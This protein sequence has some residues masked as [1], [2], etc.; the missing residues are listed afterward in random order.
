MGEVAE[1]ERSTKMDGDRRSLGT[2]EVVALG[3]VVAATALLFAQTRD[4]A[5]VGWDTYP[6]I[7]ASRIQSTEDFLRSFGGRLMG[8]DLESAYYRPLLNATLAIDYAINGLSPFGYQATNALLFAGCGLA[9]FAAYRQLS[10]SRVGALSALVVFLLHPVHFE[11]VPVVSRRPELLCLLFTLLAVAG[12]ARATRR[13]PGR[14]AWLPA[15][16]GLLA[17]SSKETG[18]VSLPLVWLISLTGEPGEPG[19]ERVRRSAREMWPW[20]P[21]TLTLI[22]IRYGVLG[23]FVG[24]T[25]D[26]TVALGLLYPAGLRV[27]R[28]LILAR[29]DLLSLA[30]AAL[31]LAGTVSCAAACFVTRARMDA[32]R[33]AL[34]GA[35]LLVLATSLY[36]AAGLVQPWYLEIPLAGFALMWGAAIETLLA[37]WRS[38]TAFARCVVA[39]GLLCGVAL[40]SIWAPLSPLFHRYSEWETGSAS[41]QRYLARLTQTIDAAPRGAVL[42]HAG[43]RMWARSSGDGP[44][45]IGTTLMHSY[46]IR[47][48]A[49]LMYPDDRVR[50]EWREF[51][52]LTAGPDEVVIELRYGARK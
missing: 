43:P 26:V 45:L 4:V 36:A 22:A 37:S 16:F 13:H 28:G 32:A 27:L 34:A 33:V 23:G 3:L 41:A 38:N 39:G 6:L 51:E 12:Q 8:E 2:P 7:L 49:E 35:A 47:A 21:M 40:L 48:W 17:M 20:L 10:P 44:R 18:F 29:A 42:V 50:V 25:T 46:S 15:L 5:L 30:A 52:G 11:V 9:L 31:P 14:A 19:S 1:P 24:R